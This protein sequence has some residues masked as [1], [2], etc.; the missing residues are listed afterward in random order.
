MNFLLNTSVIGGKVG[1]SGVKIKIQD[2]KTKEIKELDA[3]CVLVA[4]GRKPN[5]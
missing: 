1:S 4:T 5:T 3:E 2:N